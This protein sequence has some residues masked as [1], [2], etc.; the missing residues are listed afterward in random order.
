[1]EIDKVNKPE[2]E[3]VTYVRRGKS[4]PR[5]NSSINGFVPDFIGV[6]VE[7]VDKKNLH[8]NTVV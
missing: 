7:Y 2:N 1:M 4:S 8:H 3:I 6:E 5:K